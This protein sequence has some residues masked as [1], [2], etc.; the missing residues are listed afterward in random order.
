M[1]VSS[2]HTGHKCTVVTQWILDTRNLWPQAIKTSQ[3]Q[4]HAARALAL[5]TT[6]EGEDV[7]RYLH[8][9]D[10]KMA[11]GSRLL[12]R[13]IIARHGLAT[14]AQ[15]VTVRNKDT[16]PIFLMPDGSEPLIF[17][18]SHQNGL[19]VLVAV[20]NPSAGVSLGVDVVCPT[21]RKD[22]DHK[23]VAEEGWNSFVEMH[24]EVLS[25][26]DIQSLQKL[27]FR[28]LDKKLRYFYT[29]WC[30]REAYV[31]MTGEALLA[32]WLGAL[33][34]RYF[35]PPED[36][37]PSQLEIWFEGRRLRNVDIDM[38]NVLDNQFI[39]CTSV[40]KNADESLELSEFDFIDVEEVIS[41]GEG[42][43]VNP[44]MTPGAAQA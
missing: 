9:K 37:P 41:F 43:D 5:I 8:V 12:K 15:A 39:I 26:Y 25:P 18:I 22:R 27:P 44:I 17:N 14:W 20:H 23:M 24:G 4:V 11:L 40:G 2:E 3:L 7:L 16:K 35:S 32:P 10:A 1:A 31:K 6:Q 29:L 30:L 42:E 19:V 33:E 28:D 13:Y 21:E 38:V 36:A 34:M